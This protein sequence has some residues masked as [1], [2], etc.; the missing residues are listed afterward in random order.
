MRRSGGSP[1][2][3]AAFWEALMAGLYPARPAGHGRGGSGNPEREFQS[4]FPYHPP[5]HM[6]PTTDAHPSSPPPPL[7]QR[8]RGRFIVFD[9]NEGCGKSTQADMLR[10]R[11]VEGPAAVVPA[12]DV[13]LVRDPGTTGIAEQVRAILLDPAHAQMSMR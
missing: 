2:S 12:D 8:L 3:R 13:L 9:G 10:R 6:T 5:P 1:S 11:L 7:A 4:R